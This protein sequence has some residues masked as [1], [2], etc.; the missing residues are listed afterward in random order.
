MRILISYLIFIVQ[1]NLC[2]VYEV[3][4]AS[5]SPENRWTKLVE[6]YDK[7]ALRDYARMIDQLMI[8]ENYMLEFTWVR[9]LIMLYGWETAPQ[10][11]Y[12][13]THNTLKLYFQ[14]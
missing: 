5:S 14:L 11:L 8:D 1:F 2:A 3:N 10:N 9:K 4:L 6:Q 13:S 12:K 7:E